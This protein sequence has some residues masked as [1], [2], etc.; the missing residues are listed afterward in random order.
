MEMFIGEETAVIASPLRIH[1][2]D[3]LFPVLARYA[4]STRSRVRYIPDDDAETN[5]EN[6][7]NV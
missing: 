7:S 2:G 5:D 4:H 6:E 3:A 1:E